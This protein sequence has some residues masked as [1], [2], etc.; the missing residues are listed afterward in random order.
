MTTDSSKAFYNK[1]LEILKSQYKPEKIQGKLHFRLSLTF[2]EN[3]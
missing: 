2:I 3:D 1:F